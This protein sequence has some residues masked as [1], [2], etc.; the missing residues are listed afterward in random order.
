M[1]ADNSQL[2]LNFIGKNNIFA[3]FKVFGNIYNFDENKIEIPNALFGPKRE[4]KLV[5]FKLIPKDNKI[6][7][8]L[9][10]YL[11]I[12]F[13][14][15]KV[16]C[17]V[18]E[19][20][21]LLFDIIFLDNKINAIN[22]RGLELKEFNTLENDTRT[23]FVFINSPSSFK[24]KDI[25][26][27]LERY[28]PLKLIT[29]KSFQIAFFDFYEDAYSI[30][31]INQEEIVNE[32]LIVNIL[33]KN[34]SILFEFLHNI[35]KL[36]TKKEENEEEYKQLCQKVPLEK[37][38]INFSQDKELLKKE[39]DN[40]ELYYL[41]YIY[42]LWLVYYTI[43]FPDDNKNNKSNESDNNNDNKET[44][45]KDDSED[46]NES[47][48]DEF[49]FNYT[50]FEVFEN[51]TQFYEKYKKDNSLLIY[52]KVLLLCSNIIY[53]IRINNIDEYNNSKL[54]Y[55]KA[56][57]LNE[58]SVFG[59]SF[60]FLRDFVTNLNSKSEIFYPLL[61]LDSG[62]YYNNKNTTYG[63]D[64]QS[65]ENIKNHLTDLIPEVFFVFEK[66]YLL[67]EEK[68]F[69]YKGY[70]IIF[71]NKL[72]ILNNY[73][74][75][76]LEKDKN[77]REAKHYAT[78]TSKFFMHETFGH[79]KFIY[80][81]NE[82][83][84]SPRHFFNQNKEFITMITKYNEE[85]EKDKNVYFRINQDHIGGE[86]GNFL[87]YFFGT[88]EDELVL[89]LIYLIKNIGKLIDN[90]KYFTDSNLKILKKY[91]IYKYELDKR[92]IQ[93]IEDENSS[94]E[95]DLKKM[96]EIMKSKGIDLKKKKKTHESKISIKR[97]D[98]LDNLFINTNEN[99]IKNYSYYVKKIQESKSNYEFSKYMKKLLFK[100]L[101]L[102]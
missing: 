82:G 95:N 6:E 24:V 92:G 85:K 89:N 23:R 62:L 102:E 91:I 22:Y 49:I 57:G 65:C 45:N 25:P 84:S 73:H 99:K 64:F 4:K 74:G 43:F 12:Y 21:G 15:N 50:I 9:V 34:K 98:E 87:D 75:K 10:F 79:T 40:E 72:V 56:E 29:N 90:V 63:F 37:N 42:M 39:F 67:Q 59:L 101:K 30:K 14:L 8:E 3:E 96:K 53:F 16:Y 76:P 35:E 55:I 51:I 13:G 77:E 54:D 52:Q 20:N 32:L 60:Q 33:K 58:N 17:F 80:K 94:L 7:K 86:S 27:K 47:I 69:T 44:E 70:K 5:E 1:E 83:P 93:F 66:K 46:E 18:E 48:S 100:H 41:I 38:I 88:H 19:I 71:L 31:A 28:I 97:K 68:G 11:Y 36:I 61:L 78:R 26:L 2:I 81:L